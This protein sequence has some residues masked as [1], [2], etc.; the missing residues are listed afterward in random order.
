MDA[1][2]EPAHDDC[3]RVNGSLILFVKMADF[4]T[5]TGRGLAVAVVR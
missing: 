3:A 1:R 4:A 5:S 2:V